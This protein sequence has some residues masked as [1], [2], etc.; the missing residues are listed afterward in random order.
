MLAKQIIST[1][2]GGKAEC[3]GADASEE[4]VVGGAGGGISHLI[5]EYSFSKDP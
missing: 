1:V 3:V 2:T 4:D 5:N